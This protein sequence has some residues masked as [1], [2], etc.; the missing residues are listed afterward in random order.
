MR[1]SFG[2]INEHLQH[3]ANNC[4][5]SLQLD[6]NA[7]GFRVTTNDGSRDLSP[8]LSPTRMLEWIDAFQIGFLEK[9]DQVTKKRG[10]KAA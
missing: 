10:K 9:G 4:G 6:H 1:I 7:A 3:V 5:L 2:K 8:R